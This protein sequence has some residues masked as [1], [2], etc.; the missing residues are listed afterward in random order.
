MQL[1]IKNENIRFKSTVYS[2]KD[3]NVRSTGTEVEDNKPKPIQES[4]VEVMQF[5]Q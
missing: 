1:L 5:I 2:E 4:C 3:I